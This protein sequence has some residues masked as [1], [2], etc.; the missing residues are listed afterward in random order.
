MCGA[1]VAAVGG[2][3]FDDSRVFGPA[4]FPSPVGGG[5]APCGGKTTSSVTLTMILTHLEK[6]QADGGKRLIAARTNWMGDVE[7]RINEHSVSA[8][9]YIGK[10]TLGL[11]NSL[12]SQIAALKAVGVGGCVLPG[13]ES[14]DSR[15]SVGSSGRR[16]NDERRSRFYR[17]AVR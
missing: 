8:T 15:E 5:A 7:T 3:A 11:C 10:K 12:L 9:T 13:A 16:R 6:A 14:K 17:T 1:W 2:D 4:P